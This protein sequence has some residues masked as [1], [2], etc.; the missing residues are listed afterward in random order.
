MQWLSVV[1][2]VSAWIDGG[3][4]AAQATGDAEVFAPPIRMVSGPDTAFA[5]VADGDGRTVFDG[6]PAQSLR[7]ADSGDIDLRSVDSLRSAARTHGGSVR[8]SSTGFAS[9]A[10]DSLGEPIVASPEFPPAVSPKGEEVL[11]SRP[12]PVF[13]GGHG[14]GFEPVPHQILR[15][16]R[17]PPNSARHLVDGQH[18]IGQIA[19]PHSAVPGS[20]VASDGSVPQMNADASFN[21]SVGPSAEHAAVQT[22]S[23]AMWI[24]RHNGLDQDPPTF[25]VA[26]AHH[27]LHHRLLPRHP[28]IPGAATDRR[29]KTPYSYGYFGASGNRH[30]T[31]HTGY[32]DRDTEWRFR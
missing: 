24:R 2:A 29:W 4:I 16:P 27:A 8:P 32:R 25:P 18:V 28:S 21:L 3:D 1:F 26:D 5:P 7:V 15:A 6:P 12:R 9:P 14:G 22:A 31:H 20:M 23:M 19:K 10:V 13:H 17:I 11:E 30:W